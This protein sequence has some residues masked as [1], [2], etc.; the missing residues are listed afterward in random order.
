MTSIPEPTRQMIT[1]LILVLCF[2][3]GAGAKELITRQEANLPDV[4]PAKGVFPGPKVTQLSP[5]PKAMP[6][7]SPLRLRLRFETRG[8]RIDLNSLRVIY[9]KNPLVDLTSRIREYAGLTGI[10][11]PDAEVPAGDHRII[12][13]VSDADGVVGKTEILLQVRN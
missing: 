5:D 7:R 9:V 2:A 1:A 3:T 13:E 10:D 4:L 12:I 11:M 6:T 8:S